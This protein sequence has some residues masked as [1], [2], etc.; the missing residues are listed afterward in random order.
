VGV[1]W[2]NYTQTNPDFV[3]LGSE[4]QPY[5]ILLKFFLSAFVM[6][7]IVAVNYI[8]FVIFNMANAPH[9]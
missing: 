7:C 2:E 1:G 8:F 9:V 5:N 3:I 6:L 4:H